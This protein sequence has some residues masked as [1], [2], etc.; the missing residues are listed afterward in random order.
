MPRQPN[1]IDETDRDSN[2]TRIEALTIN[3]TT[4]PANLPHSGSSDVAVVI[5]ARDESPVLRDTLRSLNL[6]L[7]PNDHIHVVADHCRDLTAE[8]ARTMGAQVHVRS[9]GGNCGKGP[10]LAWWLERTRDQSRRSQIV[11]VLDADT[12]VE[13]SFFKRIHSRFHS[14]AR[15]VQAR[16]E[17]VVTSNSPIALLAALSEN[18]EQMVFE[19]FRSALGWPARLRGTGMAFRRDVLETVAPKLR[20]LTEDAEL[21]ILLAAARIPIQF[22]SETFVFDP[23]PSDRLGAIRQRSRWLRGQGQVLLSHP[24]AIIKLLFQGPRGW[25]LVAG[26]VAK[27]KSLFVPLQVALLVGLWSLPPQRFELASPWVLLPLLALVIFIT[28]M[29]A[30]LYAL[31]VSPNRQ[32]TVLSLFASPFYLLMWLRSFATALVAKEE[33]PRTRRAV[34]ERPTRESTIAG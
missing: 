10:A 26:M 11:V 23:K 8:T 14:G 2:L 31:L 16:I 20:T 7:G 12:Y 32:A 22:A 13:A 29:L 33:W 1:G 24:K 5:L 21:T 30:L 19:R 27:P 28:N 17:P 34:V 3:E 4:L 15:V 18:T 9:G 6:L 25:F